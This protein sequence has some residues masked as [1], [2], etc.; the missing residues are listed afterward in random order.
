VKKIERTI[1]LLKRGWLTALESAQQGGCLAL[2]QRVGELRE[3][4]CWQS[5]CKFSYRFVIVDKWVKTAGGARVKAYKI[6]RDY[7]K[8]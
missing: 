8:G 3:E 6:T 5:N 4:M 2:S 7:K 1:Q